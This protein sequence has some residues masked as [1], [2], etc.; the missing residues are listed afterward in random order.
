MIADMDN[1]ARV[2][3]LRRILGGTPGGERE[4]ASSSAKPDR[5]SSSSETSHRPSDLAV[6]A[7]APADGA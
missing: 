4:A 3:F 1:A 7:F 2:A 5:S 6:H